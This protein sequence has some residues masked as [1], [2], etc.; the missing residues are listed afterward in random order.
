MEDE[1]LENPADAREATHDAIRCEHNNDWAVLSARH[2]TFQIKTR[3]H[4]PSLLNMVCRISF[5]PSG[6]PYCRQL[7]AEILNTNS[8][9][10]SQNKM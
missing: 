2:E 7:V 4:V 8:A 1:L 3:L 9:T 6:V 10:A 5:D